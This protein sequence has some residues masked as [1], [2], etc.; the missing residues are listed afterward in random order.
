MGRSSPCALSQPSGQTKTSDLTKHDVALKLWLPE[1]VSF[2]LK[3]MG[4]LGG[5]SIS[6][7]LRRFLA[8]HCYGVCAAQVISAAVPETYRAPPPAMFSRSAPTPPPGK[9]RVDTYWIPELGKNVA[10]I[11]VWVPSRLQSDL[12]ALAGHV[13]IPLLQY[14]REIVI[15]RACSGTAP[16][17]NGHRCLRLR[18]SPLLMSGV[19]RATARESGLSEP[20][21]WA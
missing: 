5:E 11:K 4:E 19:E 16:Y 9:V 13:D 20:S 14:V 15:S 21:A 12:E 3:E 18:R 17:R 2:A 6:E 1:P 8:Q 10:P 7:M